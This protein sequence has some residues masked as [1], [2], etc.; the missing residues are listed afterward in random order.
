MAENCDKIKLVVRPTGVYYPFPANGLVC[1]TAPFSATRFRQS[2]DNLANGPTRDCRP[3][4]GPNHKRKGV[5][6][7]YYA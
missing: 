5:R 6:H 4:I 3:N 1:L 2:Q 7:G